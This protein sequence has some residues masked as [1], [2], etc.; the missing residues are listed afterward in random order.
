MDALVRWA[1]G[2]GV[3]RGLLGGEQVWLVVGAVALLLRLGRKAARKRPE[4][5][6]SEKLG[7]GERLV[8]T[9]RRPSG[10]NGRREG[11]AAQ[12]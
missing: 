9:H 11:P 5:V 1:L 4:L 7:V 8:I 12:P 10:H 3:R 6:F 2:R